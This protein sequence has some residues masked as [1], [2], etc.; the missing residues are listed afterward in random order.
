MSDVK[1]VNGIDL[2]VGD[3]VHV[4][5]E[6]L[7]NDRGT[8]GKTGVIVAIK[9]YSYD[10]AVEFDEDVRGVR[11]G[12]IH[13]CFGL[14]PSGRGRFGYGSDVMLVC[15]ERNKCI[16]ISVSFDDMIGGINDGY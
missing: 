10:I 12:S 5:P 11:T 16:D 6:G 14:V 1:D 3:I 15:T 7:D 9:A 8:A 4:G 13:N 2:H